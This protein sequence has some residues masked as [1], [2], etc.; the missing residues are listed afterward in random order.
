MSNIRT[1][2]TLHRNI[3]RLKIQFLDF[4][5]IVISI[6]KIIVTFFVVVNVQKNSMGMWKNAWGFF[7]LLLMTKSHMKIE[8]DVK[9]G[10]FG[11][12][13][14]CSERAFSKAGQVATAWMQRLPF[15]HIQWKNIY[16]IIIQFE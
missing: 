6:V 4:E 10:Y 16:M 9:F 12:H 13:Q 2:V 8:F 14:V 3:E 7:F 1:R 11:G 5:L 15:T